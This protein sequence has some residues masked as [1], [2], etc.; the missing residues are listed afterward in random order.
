MTICT[1]CGTHYDEVRWAPTL[2]TGTF[3]ATR[4]SCPACSTGRLPRWGVAWEEIWT[5]AEHTLAVTLLAG[6]VWLGLALGTGAAL[7]FLW[8]ILGL[9]AALAVDH[10]SPLVPLFARRRIVLASVWGALALLETVAILCGMPPEGLVAL[11][12][13]AVAGLIAGLVGS[14]TLTVRSRQPG[15]QTNLMARRERQAA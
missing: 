8:P 10:G 3:R 2:P 5:T 11:G 4:Q 15:G 12:W 6:V 1:T 13:L 9:V 14:V 7:P